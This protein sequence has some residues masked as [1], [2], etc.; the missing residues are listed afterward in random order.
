MNMLGGLSIR[1]RIIL[2]ILSVTVPVVGL[3]LGFVM[4]KDVQEFRKNMLDNAVITAQTV[5]G[6]A[7][8]DLFFNDEIA[9]RE[10]LSG[11]SD[12]PAIESAY[13]YDQQGV[14]FASRERPETAPDIHPAQNNL[15]EF[16]GDKLHVIKP[17]RYQGVDYGSIYLLLSTQQLDNKL[18]QYGWFLLGT[19]VVLIVLAYFLANMLQGVI[20]KPIRTL[21]GVA[22]DISQ[23]MDYSRRVRHDSQDVI[24]RL[25]DAF[26]QMLTRIQQQAL[27]RDAADR[28]REQSE[29]RLARFFQATNEGVFFHE[30][31]NILDINPGLTAIIGY[32]P[33]E[34]IGRNVLEFIVPESHPEV[35]KNI[36]A[37]TKFAYETQAITKSGAIIPMEIRART[38]Q[39]EG[40]CLRVVSVQDVTERKRAAQA[41]QQA[42][43]RLEEKVAERTQALAEANNHLLKGIEERKKAEQAAKNANRAK[44]TFLANM[45][46][47]LRT[48]LNSIIGFTGILKEGLAGDI[49]EEQARQLGMVYGS[50][51]H[52]L[53]LINDILDLSKVEAGKVDAAMDDFE[54]MPLLEEIQALMQPQADAKGLDLQLAGYIPGIL[55]SDRGKLRQ[56]LLNL[57]SNAVKFTEQG[58]VTLVFRQQGR[59]VIFEVEDTGIGIREE[60]M[61]KIFQAFEQVDNGTEREYEGT[62]L[63]LAISQR[64]IKLLGGDISARSHPGEGSTFHIVLHDVL[65]KPPPSLLDQ[66]SQAT[67][68]SGR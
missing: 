32:R 42:Y 11:L 60:N 65:R 59:D 4:L 8:S 38:V 43:D 36:R 50:A 6:Y 24:G 58:S 34:V 35:L 61:D 49:N 17:I 21:A 15:A 64:F 53:E 55:F 28:A 62:G 41:L 45:S 40:H 54:L 56:V 14:L 12:T 37:G 47:E 29:E 30:D 23:S 7:A 3:G 1:Q 19:G 2:V 22:R 20:T 68:D 16:R 26:N 10:T 25:Y 13:L 52:L 33:D 46:H 51:R 9:A 48:P 18:R 66:D 31:G 5:G 63:G 44:S 39:F 27:A 67:T 57:L